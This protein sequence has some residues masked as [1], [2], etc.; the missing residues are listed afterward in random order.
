VHVVAA[1]LGPADPS[2]TLRV[3]AHVIRSAETLVADIFAQ[4]IRAHNNAAVSKPVSKEPRRKRGRAVDLG[5]VYRNRTDDLRITRGLLPRTE[6]MTCT[7]DAAD[8]TNS[9]DCTGFSRP[10]VP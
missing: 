2:V 4:T 10:V 6:S 3:Y 8:R 1:R 5:E 9:A 7:D